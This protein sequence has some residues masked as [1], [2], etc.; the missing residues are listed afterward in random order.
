[1]SR[2]V[3]T[4]ISLLAATLAGCGPENPLG[5]QALLG[6]VTLDGQPLEQGNI[7]FHPLEGDV[8]SGGQITGGRYSIPAHE[9][10]T[11]GKYR[12]AIYRFRAHAAAAA[13]PH[14]GRRPAALAQAQS[15][16]RVEQQEP[17][18][19]RSEEGRSVQVRFRDRHQKVGTKK[20]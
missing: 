18:D 1:M 10:A 14:A 3:L 4:A 16:A 19:H 20:K 13:G 9:G 8:Q 6:Q 11:P 15:S 7:E 17:R 2:F 12:V 5:P